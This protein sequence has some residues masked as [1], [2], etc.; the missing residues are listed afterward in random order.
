MFSSPPY[1]LSQ[2]GGLQGSALAAQQVD[3]L[4]M[5]MLRRRDE[6]LGGDEGHP[7]AVTVAAVEYVCLVVR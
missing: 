3:H 5:A 4:R 7:R 1:L 6:E 2:A